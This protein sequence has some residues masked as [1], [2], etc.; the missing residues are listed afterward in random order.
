[1]TAMPDRVPENRYNPMRA[2]L[3]RIVML[4]QASEII[5]QA[6]MAEAIGCAERTL[7]AYLSGDRSISDGTLTAAA[8]ALEVHANQIA[9]HAAAMRF[10]IHDGGEA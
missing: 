7:R 2:H 3:R 6:A 4:R 9:R 8:V 1:M 5:G 10:L